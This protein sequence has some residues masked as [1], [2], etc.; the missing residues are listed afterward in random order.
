MTE[1]PVID[2]VTPGA[3]TEQPVAKVEG[4]TEAPVV[5]PQVSED[6]DWQ[7]REAELKQTFE[8][9]LSRMK[10]SYDSQIRGIRTDQTKQIGDFEN[11]IHAIRMSSMDDAQK[12]V[13]E[14]NLYKERSGSLQEQ[15]VTSQQQLENAQ[16]MG[17][18]IQNFLSLG[19]DPSK[20]DATNP[21]TLAT[22]GWEGVALRMHQQDERIA[23][24]MKQ[25]ADKPASGLETTPTPT[26]PPAPKVPGQPI[27]P[28][29][30]TQRGGETPAK[31]AN[32]GAL[33]Q[34]LE[35]A[36]GQK[37]TVEKIYT[38]VQQG[39]LSHEIL[40]FQFE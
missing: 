14:L 35:A 3:G 37:F 28:A 1:N 10:S 7:K 29:V 24:L 9:D 31:A 25:Q 19:V 38:W 23:E 16:S 6:V 40:P 4:A 30:V 22:S 11:Q 26:V 17:I 20:L 2:T 32:W 15:L 21:E 27:A 39:R 18:Y 34:Q 12:Q 13:Y 8:H 36:H 5:A 33:I